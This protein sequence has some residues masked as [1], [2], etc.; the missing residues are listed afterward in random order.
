MR[1]TDR[2]PEGWVVGVRRWKVLQGGNWAFVS[3]G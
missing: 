2:G 1:E 3:S